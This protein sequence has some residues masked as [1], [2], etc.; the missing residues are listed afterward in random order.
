MMPDLIS[1]I[2]GTWLNIA[3]PV[4]LK[5]MDEFQHVT[6]A[7]KTFC[8]RLQNLNFTNFQELQEWVDDAPKVW[9]SKCRETALD[10][11]RAKLAQGLGESKSVERVET[12]TISKSEGKELAANG[13]G[14]SG[15]D[16]DWGAAWEGEEA[17]TNNEATDTKLEG[18]ED[19]G[20]D[21]W[22]WGDDDPVDEQ[23][24][25]PAQPSTEQPIDD[26]PTEAWGWGEEAAEAAPD[27]PAPTD[28]SSSNA[29]TR[30]LTLK[31]T[32]NIS[33]MPEPVLALVSTILEDAALLIG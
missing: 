33:S 29:Q 18:N 9:L 30:E 14:P 21:A 3:V 11:V 24:D 6:E 16:N 8:N 28:I 22:G 25:A 7:V 23:P 32:Y 26:D 31:E 12:R 4:S 20:T 5:E 10:T 15:D 17:D 1:R 19:D 2:V 13:V 27:E